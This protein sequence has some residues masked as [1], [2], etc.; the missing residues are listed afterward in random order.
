M[1]PKITRRPLANARSGS[2]PSSPRGK[3]GMACD[4]FACDGTGRVNGE[5]LMQAAGQN[6][7][8]LLKKRG[9]GH[10][11]YPTEAVCAL[12]L[13]SYWWVTRP[14]LGYVSVSSFI[15]SPSP[16]GKRVHIPSY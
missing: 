7:K 3:T 4:A 16:L 11:P 14:S 13:A 15:G 1:R 5:A 12:F 2:N 9:W 8:R 6:L 10:R